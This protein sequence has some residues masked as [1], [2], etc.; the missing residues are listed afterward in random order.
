MNLADNLKRIRKENNL[1]QEQ[2]AEKLGVSRQSVSKWEQGDSYPEMDKMLQIAKLFNLNIDDLLNQNIKEVN[3]EKQTKQAFNKGIDEF[4]GFVTKSLDMFSSLKAKGKINFLL[5]QIIIVSVLIII[6]LILG[7]IGSSIVTNLFSFLPWEV[8]SVIHSIFESIYVICALVLGFILWFSIFKTR[9]LDYYVVVKEEPKEIISHE[10]IDIAPNHDKKV[11]LEKK[12]E[13][14]VIRDPKHSE[15]KF[16]SGLIKVLLFIIKSIAL[17]VA[18]FLCLSFI[19]LIVL[20]VLSFLINNSGLFFIGILLLILSGI[21][22]NLILLVVIF[23]FIITRKSKKRLLLCLF[24]V[25][26]VICGVGMGL[27]GIGFTKFNYLSNLDSALYKNSDV[28]I[29]M[30]E[31][32]VIE[33][34]LYCVDCDKIEFA[35]ENR[36]DIRIQYNYHN[37]YEPYQYRNGNYLYLGIDNAEDFM[38]SIR[39][40]ISDLNNKKIVDYANYNIVVY[41]SKENILKLQNNIKRQ[42]ELELSQNS[43]INELE[44]RIENYQNKIANLEEK[45]E[46][47]LNNNEIVAE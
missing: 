40:I 14:I 16:I 11:V 6:F 2:L 7:T 15:Y 45:I 18:L 8:S 25:S 35:E 1:S 24:L 3:T 5:E 21:I 41:A 47:Y 31:S 36:N 20:F 12:Q 42:K 30:Q 22:I 10:N 9:Y 43:Y 19:G 38:N 34:N 26:L 39:V 44:E 17:L 37:I 32:L 13:K 29:P 27:S 28:I 46:N 33:S 23:N 4:L